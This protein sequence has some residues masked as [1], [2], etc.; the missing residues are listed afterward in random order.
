MKNG[1]MAD[2]REQV[3][4]T[5]S[6]LKDSRERLSH[7]LRSKPTETELESVILAMLRTHNDC[8]C[9]AC[10]NASSILSRSHAT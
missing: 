10:K 1:A 9:E 2:A 8:G 7:A 6:S 5:I 4:R 3:S